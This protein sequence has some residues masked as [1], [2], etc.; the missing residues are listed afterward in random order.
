M[1]DNFWKGKI[2]LVTGPCGFLGTWLLMFLLRKGAKIVGIVRDGISQSNFSLSGLNRSIDIVHG[3][4]SDYRTIE[5]TLNDYEVQIVFHLAAQAIV[6]V[7]NK[8]PISTFISNV[9]GTLNILEAIRQLGSVERVIIAS[10]DKVYGDQALPYTEDNPL[11]CQY[12]YDVSKA[13]AELVTKAYCET[14]FKVEKPQVYVGI[15]RCANLYGGG[16]MNFTRIIPGQIFRALRGESLCYNMC[17]REFLYVLD[18]VQAYLSLA[19][20]LDRKSIDGEAFNFGTGEG[21]SMKD[22]VCEHIL[23]ICRNGEKLNAYQRFYSRD[24][25]SIV[26]AKNNQKPEGNLEYP[27]GEIRDQFM[28]CEKALKLLRWKPVYLL[29]EGIEDTYYWYES[30]LKNKDMKRVNERLIEKYTEKQRYMQSSHP[31]PIVET[32]SMAHTRK[33]SRAKRKLTLQEV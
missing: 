9:I 22:L 7:A 30:W 20:K 31:T 29:Q 12:P 27:P 33:S 15:T 24:G 21:I 8:S 16:D 26:E 10:S 11:L 19:E 14:Y 17:K 5:R 18:A 28:S 3:S 2:V 1:E 6:K 13:A 25:K 32:S 4:I 23:G